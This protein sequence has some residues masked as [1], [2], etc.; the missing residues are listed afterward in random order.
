MK[1]EIN[2]KK[3]TNYILFGIILILGI[4]FRLINL[5]KSGGLWYDE[6][7]IYSIAS[8]HGISGMFNADSHRFLLFPFYYIIYNIW[9][10]IFGDS[11]LVIRLMSVFFDTLGIITAYFVGVQFG[12]NFGKNSNKTG[13]IYMLL[14]AINSSFIYYAQEAK[15]YSLTFFIINLILLFWLKFI[16]NK[17]DNSDSRKNL[18]IL[19]ILNF[20]L[21]AAYTSQILFVILLFI[22]SVLYLVPR[23][24]FKFEEIL[25]YSL[26]FII[27]LLA[28]LLFKNYI[29]GNFDA[30]VYDNSF[31]L[32]AVQNWFTPMLNGLQNNVLNYHIYLLSHILSIKLWLFI[33]FPSAVIIYGIV[34]CL[35][36]DK[37][38]VAL[39]LFLTSFIYV[40]LHIIF[41]YLT[42]YNVLVRYTL[43]ALPVLL[44]TASAGLAEIK[45]KI[46]IP[47]FVTINILGIISLTGAP[48]IKRPDGYK[49]LGETLTKAAI[50]QNY[51]YIMPIRV[52]L[53]DKYFYIKGKR[54][55][56]YKLTT[57]EAQKTYLTQDEI[58]GINTD[59][60]NKNKYIKRFLTQDN[61]PKGFESYVL[62]NFSDNNHVV[63]I[64]DTSIAILSDSQLKLAVQSENFDKYPFQFLRLSKLYNNM[65]TVFS[66]NYKL[67][68]KITNKNWE[69]YIFEIQ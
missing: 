2:M 69:I 29:S 52:N 3:Q 55:S 41:T 63:I 59:K 39:C 19:L 31:I 51:S 36:S 64:K 50:S 66:N 57:P 67:K 16:D 60:N 17:L 56:I 26:S 38:H 20:I 25:I 32:L 22:A 23:K 15:F 8:Q 24:R 42:G 4:I 28:S 65:I 49:I 34:K 9:I 33:V 14:Y 62:S 35:K 44:L 30:V 1:K 18:W 21:I 48:Y 68:Q 58:N 53:L 61:I 5:D 54:Y 11:D 7:T 27:P 6:A 37:T 43:P 10:T 46:I 12:K 47:L 40:A 13:L 45:N